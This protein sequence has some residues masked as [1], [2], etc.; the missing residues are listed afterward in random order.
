MRELITE[1]ALVIFLST[2]GAGLG[3]LLADAFMA[4][5]PSFSPDLVTGDQS[6]LIHE[7]LTMTGMLM[8]AFWALSIWADLE[9]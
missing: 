8:G 4:I 7:V 5:G 3:F 1:I 6:A 9:A 2:I